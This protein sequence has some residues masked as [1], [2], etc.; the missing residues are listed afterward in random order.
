VISGG[1]AAFAGKRVLLL[2]GPLGPFFKHL[3]EDLRNA[4]AT[5]LKI[6]FTGGDLLFTCRPFIV[7]RKGIDKWEEY[8]EKV[9]ET[10]DID[11]VLLFGDCRPMHRIAHKIAA[12]KGVEIGVFE[13]G[14]IRPD[15]VTLERHGV[16]AHSRMP[17]SFD[18][19]MREKSGAIPPV[20]H[21]GNM[22]WHAVCWAILY[23][24]ASAILW[25][26]FHRYQHHR[27]LSVLEC[28]PW[29][30][31]AWRKVIYRRKEQGIQQRLETDL[32][33]RF[34]L[35]PLQVYNDA[36]VHTHSGFESVEEF[37]RHVIVS[38]ARHAERDTALVIKHHPMDRGYHDYSKVIYKLAAEV[39]IA[40]RVIYIHDQHLPT[41][42]EHA[43]GVVLINSTVGLSALTHG[44][45]LKCCGSALYDIQGLTY[46]GSLDAFWRQAA[47]FKLNRELFQ[48]FLGYLIDTTQLNGSFYRRLR[49]PRSAA[50]L[51]WERPH[52]IPRPVASISSVGQ[53]RA[54]DA[55]PNENEVEVRTAKRMQ[56]G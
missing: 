29:V 21:V 22:F 5:V 3:A 55:V 26:V 6:N 27:P 19:Y 30:R 50:G 46:Q 1:L 40:D 56:V 32:S 39:R 28:I 52:R 14:Y 18:F 7:F 31:S 53:R 51:V 37:I 54:S 16:N 25:P 49:L 20:H 36:Q 35:V 13:E 23:Y 4:G 11:T 12:R 38:F 33:K 2:Q 9:L 41:L 44:T 17:R 10:R 47:S 48:Q 24:L 43:R 34:F 42:L 15:Y 45:A 8:F